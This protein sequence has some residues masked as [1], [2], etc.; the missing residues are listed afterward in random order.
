MGYCVGGGN[1]ILHWKGHLKCR[2]QMQKILISLVLMFTELLVLLF[3]YFL[4]VAEMS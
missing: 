2:L 3:F 4:M 1:K